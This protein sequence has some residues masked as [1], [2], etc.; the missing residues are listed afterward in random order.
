M[1]IKKPVT[2]VTRVLAGNTG[3]GAMSS[4]TKEKNQQYT[5]IL[6]EKR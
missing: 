5:I 4:G 6:Q 3:L 2:T 1:T